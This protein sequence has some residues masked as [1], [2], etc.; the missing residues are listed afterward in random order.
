MP[1]K[2][3]T[4]YNEYLKEPEKFFIICPITQNWIT[5]NIIFMNMMEQKQ[6]FAIRAKGWDW[7]ICYFSYFPWWWKTINY[8]FNFKKVGK[9]WHY[10]TNLKMNIYS[11]Q[12]LLN[13]VL[14]FG[15]HELFILIWFEYD[16][17]VLLTKNIAVT[18]WVL[19]AYYNRLVF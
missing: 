18:L 10:S 2:C 19:L 8:S 12:P 9:I 6:I 14:T 11:T 7:T 5:I 3:A 17:I 15:I 1:F 16:Q 4:K 13:W